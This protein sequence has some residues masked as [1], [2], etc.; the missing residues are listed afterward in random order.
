MIS[1]RK[2]GIRNG[3]I[4]LLILLCVGESCV[5]S[6]A[7]EKEKTVA[8]E[9]SVMWQGVACYGKYTGENRKGKPE[10][11][12]EFVGNIVIH[13]EEQ[14]KIQY[15]GEWA[16]GKMNGQGALIDYERE[17]VYEGEFH[18]NKLAGNVKEY[19]IDENQSQHYTKK[20]YNNDVPY[21]VC[22]EYDG[23]NVIDYDGY[24]Y[25]VSV[26][27]ICEEAEEFVYADYI[28]YAMSDGYRIVKLPCTVKEITYDNKKEKNTVRVEDQNG[29]SYM[30]NYDVSYK[31]V[32]KN[33]MPWIKKGD[34]I[35]LFGY[36]AGFDEYGM[37]EYPV[38]DAVTAVRADRE[39]LEIRYPEGN[40]SDFLDYPYLYLYKEVKLSGKP[41]GVY[42]VTK[43]WVFFYFEAVV[44]DG[45]REMYICRV[46]NKK[47]EINTFLAKNKDIAVRGKLRLVAGKES[48]DGKYDI[49]PVVEVKKVIAG[50]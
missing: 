42:K 10:G 9:C 29:N 27:Q 38:I 30:I 36:Y 44:D 13:N 16:D 20:R 47:D 24:Y 6:Y 8:I 18:N 40:Y 25:G 50:E 33:Y 15:T 17:T 37:M 32:A 22:L 49:F 2:R 5:C 34:R 41:K 28:R 31:Y 23:D 11:Q 39:A 43:K 19:S 35:T 14:G 48:A 26:R 46:K 45:K 21:G 1:I 4:Y 7:E 3:I 12:G